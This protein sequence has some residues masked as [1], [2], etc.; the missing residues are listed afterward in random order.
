MFVQF[1]NEHLRQRSA[2]VISSM[3]STYSSG[4]QLSMR[5]R[6]LV[7]QGGSQPGQLE[8]SK[9]ALPLEEE[10]LFPEQLAARRE[11]DDL[12][13]FVTLETWRS[14]NMGIGLLVR[15]RT[16]RERYRQLLPSI[17][18][19]EDYVSVEAYNMG[20]RAKF[21]APATAAA[22]VYDRDDADHEAESLMVKSSS[23]SRINAWLP[24]YVNKEH[25]AV[26][27]FFAPAAFSTIATQINDV[28]KPIHTLQVCARLMCATTVRF[29][30]GEELM[31][32]KATQMYCDI[33][34]L[35]LQMMADYPEVGSEAEKALTQFLK[36]PS[37]RCRRVTAD[38]GDLIQFLTVS[39]QYTW[40]DLKESYVQELLRRMARHIGVIAL[41]PIGSVEELLDTWHKRV[42]ESG[43]VSMFNKLFLDTMKSNGASVADVVAGYDSRWGRLSTSQLATLKGGYAEIMK[44]SSTQELLRRLGYDLTPPA[45]AELI[46]WAIEFRQEGPVQYAGIPRK[47]GGRV[48]DWLAKHR[49]WKQAMANPP[50]VLEY[51]P[52]IVQSTPRASTRYKSVSSTLTSTSSNPAKMDVDGGEQQDPDHHSEVVVANCDCARCKV[53]RARETKIAAWQQEKAERVTVSPTSSSTPLSSTTPLCSLFI[54]GLPRDATADHVTGAFSQ[55]GRVSSVDLVIK[56][57]TGLSKG[58]AFVHFQDPHSVQEALDCLS[59]ARMQLQEGLLT[60]VHQGRHIVADILRS[61]ADPLYLPSKLTPSRKRRPT[62]QVFGNA[63]SGN[64]PPCPLTV[65]AG[66]SIHPTSPPAPFS[67]EK[68]WMPAD[69]LAPFLF[70]GEGQE[71]PDPRILFSKAYPQ[72]GKLA[73]SSHTLREQGQRLELS[74]REAV[75]IGVVVLGGTVWLELTSRERGAETVVSRIITSNTFLRID[76]TANSHPSAVL[77]FWEPASLIVCHQ[78]V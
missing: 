51:R 37:S 68:A 23:R 35:F 43:R 7:A 50:P 39:S 42:P 25:W 59:E 10:G 9:E 46:L 53:Q 78:R 28:F 2:S 65:R 66:V 72:E 8:A 30:I 12:T 55:F 1:S 14:A 49:L 31:T 61:Q 20:V 40:D 56:R 47:A 21:S 62:N 18:L 74:F 60:P 13:C 16:I 71:G 63:L 73:F 48:K 32:E 69:D 11:V 17:D 6:F 22:T 57:S 54:Q 24:L 67:V 64:V 19:V 76:P 36:V 27:R 70:A 58:Y 34:R 44:V 4:D 29:V 5:L 77:H 33:H 3:R 15:P 38:L 45:L 26:A 75:S 41:P 52:P